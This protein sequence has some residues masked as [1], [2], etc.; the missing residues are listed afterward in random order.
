MSYH[1]EILRFPVVRCEHDPASLIYQRP[2]VEIVDSGTITRADNAGYRRVMNVLAFHADHGRNGFSGIPATY[3]RGYCYRVLWI[4]KPRPRRFHDLYR[5]VFGS[6]I[7][8]E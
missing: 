2:Q 1:Y 3:M 4:K 5:N 7:N 8:V 6:P